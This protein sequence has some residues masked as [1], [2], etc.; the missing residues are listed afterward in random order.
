MDRDLLRDYAAELI[1]DH[2]PGVEWLT[3]HECAEDRD[4]FEDFT[5][6][7][8]LIVDSMINGSVVSVVIE[9]VEYSE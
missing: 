7:D 5:E 1:F 6:E 8:A 3:I 2:A 4:G 9:E